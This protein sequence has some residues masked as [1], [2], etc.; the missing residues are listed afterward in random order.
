M[1]SIEALPRLLAENPGLQVL[2]MVDSDVVGSEGY[3]Y[4]LG[5]VDGISVEEYMIDDWYGDGCVRFRGDADDTLAE[6]YAEYVLGDCTDDHN[7]EKAEAWIAQN[8]RKAIVLWVSPGE[9]E[10]VS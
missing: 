9:A 2:T 6:G 4:W 8:W 5:Y 3:S 1:E 10:C 7:M